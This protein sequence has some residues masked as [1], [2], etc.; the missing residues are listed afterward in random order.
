VLSIAKLD[1]A[2]RS[3]TV[4]GSPRC[5]TADDWP[6]KKSIIRSPSLDRSVSECRDR[7]KSIMVQLLDS[8]IKTREVLGWKGVNVLH[9]P[10]SS[11]SQKLRIFLNIKRIKWTSHVV[12]LFTNEN[13]GEY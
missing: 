8:D 11:C 3:L 1:G 4:S 10:M 12:D 5:K 7:E 9:H 13:F 6:Q 2:A